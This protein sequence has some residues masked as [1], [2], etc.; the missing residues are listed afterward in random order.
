VKPSPLWWLS[1][2]DDT[3]P[4]GHRYLGACIVEASS[5]PMALTESHLRRCNPG[6]E[7]KGVEMNDAV[8]PLIGE[9]WKNR[10]LTKEQVLQLDAEIAQAVAQIGQ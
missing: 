5:F 1:F 10:H 3:R 4:P 9:H 2:L 8:A 6:G 7:V